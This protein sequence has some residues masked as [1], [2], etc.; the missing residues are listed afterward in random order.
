MII[1]NH[2]TVKLVEGLLQ[3]VLRHP[4]GH[5]LV[6]PGLAVLVALVDAHPAGALVR[7]VDGVL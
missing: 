3:L 1:A 2:P 7:G 5:A 4:V 6:P